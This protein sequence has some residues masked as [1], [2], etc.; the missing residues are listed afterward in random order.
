MNIQTK[1]NLHCLPYLEAGGVYSLF[2]LYVCQ[3]KPEA[4]SL[5]CVSDGRIRGCLVTGRGCGLDWVHS[6]WLMAENGVIA[7]RMLEVLRE[8]DGNDVCLNF[9][10]EFCD[11][12]QAVFPDKE[13]TVDRMYG[14][15]PS[16]LKVPTPAYSIE[17]ITGELLNGIDVPDEMASL[18][19]SDYSLYTNL[20]FW[21]MVINNQLAVTGEAICDTGA[22]AAI[23]Q[24]YTAESCRGG[25]LGGMMVGHIAD[26]LINRNRV[27]VYWVAEDNTASIRVV[28]KLGFDLLLRLGC[29]E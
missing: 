13:I 21:G 26:Y 22:Y 7:Q 12:A 2:P 5:C 20:P 14:I 4:V 23:Q 24:V 27:P 1:Q 3:R 19:G 25:G 6:Y 29:I 18:I 28:E 16:H 10:L 15:I 9:P 17:M 11:T 8:R